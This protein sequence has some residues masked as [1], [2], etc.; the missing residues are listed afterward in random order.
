M[1]H[2]GGPG[3]P[4]DPDRTVPIP[5]PADPGR[6]ADAD[7]TAAI[8]RPADPGRAANPERT[9]ANPRPVDL[10]HATGTGS[11]PVTTA[12]HP[13]NAETMILPVFVTGSRKEPDPPPQPAT[14]PRPPADGALPASERGMLVFVA[15]LLGIGTIAVVLMLGVNNLN[16]KH[17]VAPHSPSSVPSPTAS[18]IGAP[19]AP[20]VPTS[21]PTP[22][23]ARSASP[24]AV[25]TTKSV[26]KSPTPAPSL[27]GQPTVL[28]YCLARNHGM[29]QPPGSGTST[30]TCDPGRRGGQAVPFT[31]EQVCDWQY[32]LASHAVVGS[33]ADASTWKCYS[34]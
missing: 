16:T 9:A 11:H 14:P 32:G 28:A 5:H 7:R 25:T 21:S 6:A 31:P 29:A 24:T 4:A 19:A 20:V 2:P 30:W 10:S 1:S 15:A 18:V 34:K 17:P 26:K 33:L 27:L 22:S 12:S 8:P 23:P 13:A 3:Y